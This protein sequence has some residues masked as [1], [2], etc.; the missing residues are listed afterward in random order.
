[1]KFKGTCRNRDGS[2]LRLTK[3]RAEIIFTLMAA[4]RRE[5][6]R[7]FHGVWRHED[8]AK[9]LYKSVSVCVPG[10]D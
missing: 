9:M 8:K 10:R 1:M 2:K 4:R 5:E 3:T 6:L 7:E